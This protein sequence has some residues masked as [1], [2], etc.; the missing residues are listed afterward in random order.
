MPTRPALVREVYAELR[1][2]LG[3]T[4]SAAEL[5]AAAAALVEASDEDYAPRFTLH[6]GGI[7]FDEWPL[8]RVFESA[9][10]KLWL[11]EAANEDAE[12]HPRE[13]AFR[14]DELMALAA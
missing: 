9:G 11:R 2:E 13:F 1:R 12:M 6:R 8:Y 5:L 4:H 10:H 3:A 14:M 7:P